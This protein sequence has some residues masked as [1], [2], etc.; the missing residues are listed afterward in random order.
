MSNRHPVTEGEGDDVSE[1][2]SEP[3]NEGFTQAASNVDQEVTE[4]TV[5]CDNRDV[6]RSDNQS[7]LT[8]TEESDTRDWPRGRGDPRW[9][10]QDVLGAETQYQGTDDI[11][12]QI[13]SLNEQMGQMTQVLNSFVTV[14]QDLK[15]DLS[16]MKANE[17]ICIV[18]Q[19]SATRV[20][21][22]QDRQSGQ[23]MIGPGTNRDSPRQNIEQ[24]KGPT[25]FQPGQISYNVNNSHQY[26]VDHVV[27]EPVIAVNRQTPSCNS[28]PEE[29]RNLATPRLADRRVSMANECFP[30]ECHIEGPHQP[31]YNQRARTD[32]SPSR[33]YR[34]RETGQQSTN[35]AELKLPV[36]NGKES[37]QVWV[38]R[39]ELIAARRGWNEDM[40]LDQLLPRLQGEA[41]DFVFEQLPKSAWSDYQELTKELNSR[42]RKVETSKTF[43]AKFSR[44]V[45]KVGET[46][47]QFAAEL[48]RLYDRAHKSRSETT[49]Q[50]DLVRRFLDGLRDD[51]ARFEVEFHKE[52]EDIDDAVY[53]VVNF[54]QTR[55]HYFSDNQPDKKKRYTRRVATE[56][57]L[58]G[59]EESQSDDQSSDKGATARRVPVKASTDKRQTEESKS[60][61]GEAKKTNV[62]EAES[63]GLLKLLLQKI[64]ELSKKGDPSN[65]HLVKPRNNETK[66]KEF[67]KRDATCFNCGK[68]GHFARECR[69][70]TGQEDN[71]FKDQDTRTRP[72]SYANRPYQSNM[73]S[74]LN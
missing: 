60:T 14:V 37:W 44:R 57:H 69:T 71:N 13:S 43:A 50:E 26:S 28:T 4:V 49:R 56:D 68:T 45:Q 70:N 58:S 35:R 22:I 11:R 12:T 59:D 42:Y 29:M 52:P 66:R 61:I 25:S 6:L 53:Q 73:N 46:A 40:K 17:G 55:R 74:T 54:V 36:F 9:G 7:R 21:L 38:N 3:E 31:D 48:K 39:F 16:V 19:P 65:Y 67:N 34:S 41:G 18:T 30:N 5:G 51:E 64:E 15:S 24:C 62:E 23:S 32:L 33:H 10:F 8:L 27:S 63:T 72:G 47:E 20:D 1:A 2:C